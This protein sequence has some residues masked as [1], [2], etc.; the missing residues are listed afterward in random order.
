MTKAQLSAR[1]EQACGYERVG[2][3]RADGEVQLGQLAGHVERRIVAE[4]RDRAGERAG[5]GVEPR[6]PGADRAGDLRR[7]DLLDPR[8]AGCRERHL[9]L[10]QR[11]RELGQQERVA[12]GGPVTGT[13]ERDVDFAARE[14]AE[15]LRDGRF[16]QPG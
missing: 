8:R 6:Q 5:G 7:R 12:A 13:G 4:Q 15:I 11:A 1:L 9:V 16:V 10:L 3:L 2:H 14:P